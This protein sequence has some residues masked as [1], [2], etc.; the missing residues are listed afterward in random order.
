MDA[1]GIDPVPIPLPKNTTDE[2]GHTYGR[3]R[4][5]EYA[6]REGDGPS[7]SALW[8]CQCECGER[9]LVR[10]AKL[11]SG[12]TVS[13]GCERADPEIRQAAR[14]KVSSRR[15]KQIA[16]LGSDARWPAVV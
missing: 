13:C 12:R 2:T 8:R 4:V 5:L 15:R 7:A 11:R 9:P 14:L 3:L 10:G 16:R 1:T 6:G